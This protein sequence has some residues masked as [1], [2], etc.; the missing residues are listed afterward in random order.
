[1]GPPSARRG[2]GAQVRPPPRAGS[3]GLRGFA[4]PPWL[5]VAAGVRKLQ[6]TRHSVH[7]VCVSVAGQQLMDDGGPDSTS[8]I[9]GKTDPYPPDEFPDK[10]PKHRRFFLYKTIAKRLGAKGAKNRAKLPGCV[11]Y[12]IRKLYDDKVSATKVGYKQA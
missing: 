9:F 5:R 3:R 12:R 4:G 6:R 8:C 7:G 10:K 11:E 1:M 2:G